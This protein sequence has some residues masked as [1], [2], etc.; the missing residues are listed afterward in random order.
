MQSLATVKSV[1]VCSICNKKIEEDATVCEDRHPSGKPTKEDSYFFEIPLEPQLKMVIEGIVSSWHIYLFMYQSNQRFK[2]P[3][4]P[5]P[6][7]PPQTYPKHLT[8]LP[9]PREGNLIIKVFRIGKFDPT[10][11]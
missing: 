7:P 10:T 6:P 9:Y 2:I 11:T 5:P 8:S 3:P 1:R 4:P